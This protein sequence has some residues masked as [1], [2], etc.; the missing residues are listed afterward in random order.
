MRSSGR[1]K[2]TGEETPVAS[3]FAGKKRVKEEDDADLI[4]GAGIG[5]SGKRDTTSHPAG[6]EKK[7]RF[8]PLT[9]AQPYICQ[10]TPLT[11]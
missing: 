10:Q 11:A 4:A 1:A 7:P 8:N 5:G 6:S 2:R 3:I 9:A